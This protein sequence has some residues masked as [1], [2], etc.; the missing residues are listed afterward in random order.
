MKKI[1]YLLHRFPRITDTFIRR[2][3]RSLQK[4]GTQISVIS[5]WTPNK[6]DTTA[7][8]LEDWR[9]QTDFLLPMSWV[10]IVRIVSTSFVRTPLRFFRTFHLA[11]SMARPGLRGLAYQLFYFVE[12]VLAADLIRRRK[13]GHIHNHIGDQSGTVA[14]LASHLADVCYS[15]TIHGWPVFFDPEGARIKEKVVNASF[16]RAI[17]YFCRSQLMMFSNCGDAS[18]FPVIHCGLDIEKYPY[19]PPAEQVRKIFCAARLSR[20]KGL[21]FLVY[22]LKFLRD[23]GHALQLRL[24]GDGPTRNELEDLT[25]KLGLSDQVRFLGFLGE[26]DIIR[27]LEASDLFVLPSFIEGLPV[28][29]MEAMAIGVP[30]I[31]TNIAGTSE[32]VE[33]GKTGLLIRPADSQGLA[34]AVMRM[35]ADHGLRL[36][37]AGLARRKVIDEFDV[38][39]ESGKLNA[40][41]LSNCR[42]V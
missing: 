21:E 24:A 34:N 25:D 19:R 26:D 31:A 28:S 23:Q 38:A 18:H 35:I 42:C 33:D 17:S 8:I 36:R 39:K 22:A 9:A 16:I 30:V 4:S 6:S 20:E 7:D 15:I 14:M 11:L 29:V 5:V 37:M 41:L 10:P 12:A 27:E 13:I 2:E 32:L 40:L 1:A 3:I